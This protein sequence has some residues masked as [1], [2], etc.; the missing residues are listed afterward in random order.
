VRNM[1]FR[2]S[3]NR[4][5]RDSGPYNRNSKMEKSCLIVSKLCLNL[6]YAQILSVEPILR[7]LLPVNGIMK[8]CTLKE[9][10]FVL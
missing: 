10:T 3:F 6:W 9:S 4:I 2:S 1:T 5:M 7:K 8:V